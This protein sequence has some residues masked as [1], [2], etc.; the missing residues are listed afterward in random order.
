MYQSLRS[1][2]P[3]Q[4]I[5]TLFVI[6]FGLLLVAGLVLFLRS[7]RE[8]DDP[9]RAQHHQDEID[10]LTQ[11]LKTSWLLIFVFWVAG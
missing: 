3:A 1:L 10:N 6:V 8:F 2:T 4:Q 11:L 5:G 9:Q 7:M